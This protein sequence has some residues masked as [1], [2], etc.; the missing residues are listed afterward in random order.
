MIRWT[1]GAY[2]GTG[3]F[4]RRNANL[5]CR[6]PPNYREGPTNVL[7]S[8][9]NPIFRPTGWPGQFMRDKQSR[10]SSETRLDPS[11]VPE[12]LIVARDGRTS[13]NTSLSTSEI[14]WTM[15]VNDIWPSTAQW[16]PWSEVNCD[17]RGHIISSSRT[18][19]LQIRRRARVGS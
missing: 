10:D 18:I 8:S 2:R 14:S 15:D 19:T 13:S 16:P 9:N 6:S 7:S 4:R 1:S 3:V 17:M 11:A 12:G 5:W